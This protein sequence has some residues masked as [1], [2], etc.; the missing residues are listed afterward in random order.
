VSDDD[1]VTELLDVWRSGTIAPDGGV[2]FTW[3][4]ADPA[5][6]GGTERF[7]ISP[8]GLELLAALRDARKAEVEIGYFGGDGEVHGICPHC[9]I[10]DEIAEVDADSRINPISFVKG[11]D[12]ARLHFTIE[13]SRP[14]VPT[15]GYICRR[16]RAT[17][18]IPAEITF[19][20]TS[21]H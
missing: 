10:P 14:D 20:G 18:S 7:H 5:G 6:G 3:P 8:L 4:V 12:A 16:C 13:T 1:P 11:T 21:T 2:T 15:Q 9:H 19:A 17:V